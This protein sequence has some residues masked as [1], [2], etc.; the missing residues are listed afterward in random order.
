MKCSAFYINAFSRGSVGAGRAPQACPPSLP[1]CPQ[2]LKAALNEA[3]A[4]LA[5]PSSA[6]GLW[7]RLQQAV[8]VQP[9]L[10]AASGQ[11]HVLPMFDISYELHEVEV[12]VHGVFKVQLNKVHNF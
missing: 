3:I 1:S 6:Q 9:Q 7:E 11:P 2:D 5:T 8:V 4:A 10:P 12:R